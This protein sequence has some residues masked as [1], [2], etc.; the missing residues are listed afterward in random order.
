MYELLVVPAGF[1]VL[2]ALAFVNGAND[3]GKIVAGLIVAT[4][5]DQPKPASI[6]RAVFW[7]ALFTGVGSVAALYVS[8]RLFLVFTQDLVRVPLGESFALSVLVAAT[9]WVVATTLIRIPVSSTHTIIGAIVLL[10]IYQYGT[11]GIQ[12]NT[13]LV[14]VLLPMAASPFLALLATYVFHR[15]AHG[16]SATSGLGPRRVKMLHW[17]SAAMTSFSRGINDAPKMAALGFFLFP[18]S[19][20]GSVWIPYAFVSLA[21]FIGSIS[22]G[23]KVTKSLVSKEEKLDDDQRLRAGLTT[24]AL[25]SAGAIFGAPISTTH[26]AAAAKAGARAN[27]REVFWSTTGSIIL[28][29]AI[30]FPVAG[31]LTILASML[32][33]H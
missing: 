1:A 28:E 23:R 14:R 22:W 17:G 16:R 2:F 20:Q 5:G 19:S 11:N 29:W 30:T 4:S 13:L 24:A 25:V 7:G 3:V 26:V 18:I 33:P 9:V 27:D 21:L 6:T 12:W 8:G 10:L 15:L 31:L 32:L